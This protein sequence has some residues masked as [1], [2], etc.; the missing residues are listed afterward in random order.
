MSIARRKIIGLFAAGAA[1]T[2]AGCGGGYDG[3]L[4]RLMWVLNLNPEFASTDVTFDATT[5]VSGLPFPAL[6]SAFEI[7]FGSYRIGLRDRSSGRAFNFDGFLVDDYSPST[8]VFYRHFTSA[9]LEGSPVGI[10]NYF[11]STESLVVE[12]DDGTGSVQTTVLTFEGSAPQAS[13]SANCRL[14]LRRAGDGVLVYDSGLRRRSDAI[15]AYPSDPVSGLVG[16]V[17]L[18]YRFGNA[19]AAS[20]PNIL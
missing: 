18:D 20:W 9:R 15:L 3:P 6:T 5:V 13:G 12:L 11:D 19:S 14:R 7:E 8:V 17:G 2:L 1:T 10:V 4:T 16:V